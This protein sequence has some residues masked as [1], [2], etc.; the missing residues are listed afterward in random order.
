M[1]QTHHHQDK[2]K[3]N[4]IRYNMGNIIFIVIAVF[5]SLVSKD[6]LDVSI[7]IILFASIVLNMVC[8]GEE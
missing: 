3:Y 6:K 7:A 1:W 8:S 2:M 5:S 4:P